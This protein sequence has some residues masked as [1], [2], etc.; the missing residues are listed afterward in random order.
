MFILWRTLAL[1]CTL[2]SLQSSLLG[3][4]SSGTE[5]IDIVVHGL[6]LA[7]R[8]PEFEVFAHFL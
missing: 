3:T 4:P 5:G 6:V 2:F 7:G 1:K 8:R